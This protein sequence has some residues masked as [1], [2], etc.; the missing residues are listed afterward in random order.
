MCRVQDR[1]LHCT[2]VSHVAA[3]VFVFCMPAPPTFLQCI[4]RSCQCC[5]SP[6]PRARTEISILVLGLQ[7]AG[8]TTLLSAVAG[9]LT[10]H[11]EEPAP[12]MGQCVH[13]MSKCSMLLYIANNSVMPCSQRSTV[14]P[15]M[16]CR[17][18][19]Q[20]GERSGSPDTQ[21]PRAGRQ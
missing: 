18:C 6:A 16:H 13:E 9:E 5:F 8:K 4:R 17:V 3:C 12:T 20:D 10:T 2:C 1:M 14:F 21:F 19:V 7:G 11:D 15:P